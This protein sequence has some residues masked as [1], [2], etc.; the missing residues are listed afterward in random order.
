MR[1]GERKPKGLYQSLD[2]INAF[3]QFIKAKKSL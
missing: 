1:W 2:Y 3:Q